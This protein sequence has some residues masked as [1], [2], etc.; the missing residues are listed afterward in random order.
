[1]ADLSTAYLQIKGILAARKRIAEELGSQW[2]EFAEQLQIILNQIATGEE[3]TL[4]PLV[5]RFMQY[6]MQSPAKDIFR[7]IGRLS[8]SAE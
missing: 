1:M 4:R 6:G 3:E 8:R 5:D 2:S 7:E